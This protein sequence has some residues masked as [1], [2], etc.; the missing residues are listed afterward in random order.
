LV[1]QALFKVQSLRR[2]AHEQED[3]CLMHGK[4]VCFSSAE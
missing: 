3:T 1:T 2:D 4:G